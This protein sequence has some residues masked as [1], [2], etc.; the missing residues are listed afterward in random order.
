MFK[1][2]KKANKYKDAHLQNPTNIGHT[3][4]VFSNKPRAY[5]TSI[6]VVQL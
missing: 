6:P 4:V 1:T 2:V 5:T 3:V